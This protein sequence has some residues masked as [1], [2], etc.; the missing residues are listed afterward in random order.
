[1]AVFVELAP[2]AG[3]LSYKCPWRIFKEVQ[4]SLIITC[5]RR[6]WGDENTLPDCRL[7]SEHRLVFS[8]HPKALRTSGS[9][10]DCGPGTP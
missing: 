4:M 7:H 8:S 2:S 1:M 10:L 5:S 3:H 6:P 9:L